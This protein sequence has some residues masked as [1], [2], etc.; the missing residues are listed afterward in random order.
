MNETNVIPNNTKKENTF[1]PIT[2]LEAKRYEKLKASP[3]NTDGFDYS[4]HPI[5][6]E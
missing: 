1:N 6:M 2:H 3:I 4:Y 5:D